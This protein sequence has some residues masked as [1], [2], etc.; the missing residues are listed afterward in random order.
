MRRAGSLWHKIAGSSNTRKLSTNESRAPLDLDQWEW[1]TLPG[2]RP[3][4]EL[5]RLG[6]LVG[7]GLGLLLQPADHLAQAGLALAPPHSAGLLERVGWQVEPE[8]Q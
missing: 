7:E 3:P 5:G 4:G 8:S 6:L 1:R 2:D